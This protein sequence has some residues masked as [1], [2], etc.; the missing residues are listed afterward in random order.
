[1]IFI[2]G[3]VINVAVGIL[4]VDVFGYA[5]AMLVKL[6]GRIGILITH[7]FILNLIAVAVVVRALFLDNYD[8]AIV[9]SAGVYFLTVGEIIAVLVYGLTVII[10]VIAVSS[11]VN[12]AGRI[13]LGLVNDKLLA[14]IIVAK[15][16]GKISNSLTAIAFLES[17]AVRRPQTALT[18]MLCINHHCTVCISDIY[19]AVASASVSRKIDCDILGLVVELN[20]NRGILTASHSE[21]V[22]L[23][24]RESTKHTEVISC[25]RIV[26]VIYSITISIQEI[27]VRISLIVAVGVKLVKAAHTGCEG[28]LEVLTVSVKTV[29]SCIVA[30]DITV[31]TALAAFTANSARI[32]I[33]DLIV[34]D[35]VYVG[36]DVVI[37][38]IFLNPSYV[39]AVDTGVCAV[40]TVLTALATLVE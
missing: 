37:G 29:E 7:V 23:T 30:L 13:G 5:L 3:T 28:D 32:S 15:E 39:T 22:G 35:L 11:V 34:Y 36:V 26:I 24:R 16:N 14:G 20:A 12:L 10:F 8:T 27:C 17:L 25:A 33:I 4:N 1:M 31:I 21:C 2:N 40:N 9:A 38:P 18:V 6:V 19:E